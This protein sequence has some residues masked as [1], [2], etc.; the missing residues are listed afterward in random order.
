MSKYSG[1]P[2]TIHRSAA[3]LFDKFAD[4][5]VLEERIKELPA[6]AREKLQNVNFTTDTISFEAPAVGV[7]TLKVTERVPNNLIKFEAQNS[8][9]PFG[10]DFHIKTISE[11]KS[12]VSTEFNVDVPLMLRPL[13]GNKLQEAADK[14]SET[15]GTFFA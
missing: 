7:M 6:E 5:T 8:P 4:L 2:A 14:F 15:M 13:I 11:D 1:K 9:I 12:E 3:D 10:I